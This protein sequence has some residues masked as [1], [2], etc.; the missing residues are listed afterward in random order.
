MYDSFA[1][2]NFLLGVGKSCLLSKLQDNKFR[3]QISTVVAEFFLK[4]M[5]LS[6]TKVKVRLIAK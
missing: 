5:I 6:D 1:L 4:E 2:Q 3:E